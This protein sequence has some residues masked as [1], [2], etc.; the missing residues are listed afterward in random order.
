MMKTLFNKEAIALLAVTLVISY[1][2][3]D[4]F[5]SMNESSKFYQFDA[6][7][8]GPV[9]ARLQSR[10]EVPIPDITKRVHSDVQDIQ[11]QF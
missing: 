3:F 8:M 5:A 7:I 9:D 2:A 11:T 6:K 10:C 4:L 1:I